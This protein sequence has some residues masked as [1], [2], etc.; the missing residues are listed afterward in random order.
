MRASGHVHLIGSIPLAS[1]ADVFAAVGER[2]GAA[3]HRIPD[4]ETGER[5]N[6]IRWQIHAFK[7]TPALELWSP[8]VKIEGIK[9]TLARPFFRIRDGVDPATIEL[10]SLGYAREAISSFSTFSAMQAA[11]RLPADA[12][13]LVCLPT[14]VPLAGT[15][16][17]PEHRAAVEP[18]IERALAREVAEISA[19]IPH[20][21]LSVQWDVAIEIVGADGGF[22][23]YYDDPVAGGI[24][25]VVRH[26]EFVPR[27]IDAGFHLCY[28]DPG[29]KHIIEPKDLGTCVTFTNR[30]VA[31][32]S[33]PIQFAHM[34]V[35]R[36]WLT[37]DY[38]RPLSDLRVPAE[39]EVYLGLVHYT[40]GPSGNDKRIGIAKR[41]LASFGVSTECGFGRRDPATVPKLL[42]FMREA[43]ARTC[44]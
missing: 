19:A 5:T 12:L 43:A 22:A 18:A 38:Y 35:P 27:D 31:T 33:R 7:G 36:D 44:G 39:T 40:D 28:G 9:D 3:V 34:P 15:F 13:F 41:H 1:A 6:W 25:R 20:D 42:E 17:V 26:L 32:A 21:K 29:H 4:G 24:E 10:P 30:I 23:L 11:G 16:I 37:D 2:L 14:A 8:A